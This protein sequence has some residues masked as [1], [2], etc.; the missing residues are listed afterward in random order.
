MKASEVIKRY[1]SSLPTRIFY[2]GDNVV[3][4]LVN[5]DKDIQ[6]VSGCSDIREETVAEAIEKD[7]DLDI[8][9]RLSSSDRGFGS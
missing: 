4:K 3:F 8:V 6:K 7:V 5:L 2:K 1:G 9:T